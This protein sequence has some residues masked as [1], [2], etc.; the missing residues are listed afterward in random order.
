[1]DVGDIEAEEVFIS[2]NP[3]SRSGHLQ[4]SLATQHPGVNNND[5][6]TED[7]KDQEALSACIGQQNAFLGGISKVKPRGA[8]ANDHLVSEATSA[9]LEASKLQHNE[10]LQLE[11]EKIRLLSILSSDQN[12]ENSINTLNVIKEG[13]DFGIPMRYTSI[14]DLYQQLQIFM[15]SG[16]VAEEFSGMV[17]DSDGQ[18]TELKFQD[19]LNES[20]KT[21]Q[22]LVSKFSVTSGKNYILLTK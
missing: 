7:R 21:K 17:V 22:L 2:K 11:K 14:D 19:Q 1:M 9:V 5:E 13:D 4:K 12:K 3:E 18:K 8:R 16:P 15:Q 10:L 20:F 6:E